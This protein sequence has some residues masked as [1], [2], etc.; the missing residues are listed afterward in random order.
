MS[1]ELPTL[2]PTHALLSTTFN[3]PP[4]NGSLTLAEIYDW[5]LEHTPNHRIFVF[6]DDKGNIRTIYWPEAV[7]AVHTGA[8][9]LRRTLDWTKSSTDVP[10]IAILAA[11]GSYDPCLKP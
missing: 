3:P 1:T 6:C 10:I 2:P 8:R 11:E 7:R 4:L 5:H 9:R